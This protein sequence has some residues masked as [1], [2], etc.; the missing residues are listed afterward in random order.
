[1]VFQMWSKK[2]EGD[3]QLVSEKIVLIMLAIILF[4]LFVAF[5]VMK[6]WGRMPKP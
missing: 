4:I 6:V 1:M 2:G 5:V 3:T